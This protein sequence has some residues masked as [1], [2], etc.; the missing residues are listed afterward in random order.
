VVET[1]VTNIGL[2]G[3]SS[4]TVGGVML[5]SGMVAKV[6]NIVCEKERELRAGVVS[7]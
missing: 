3:V 2:S 5:I 4:A 6:L 7:G 1:I